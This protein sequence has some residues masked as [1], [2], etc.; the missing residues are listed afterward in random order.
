MNVLCQIKGFNMRS[1]K[2]LFVPAA[3]IFCQPSFAFTCYLTVMKSPCWKD[4]NINIHA[5]DQANNKQLVKAQALDK[6]KFWNRVK[7]DCNPKQALIFYAKF[8]PTIWED[9]KD[10]SYF[11]K[12]MWYLPYAVDPEISAWNI[13]ICYPVDFTDV[14]IPPS[15]NGNC[16]CDEVAKN[17]PPIPK[18]IISK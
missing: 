8:N 9:A 17:I 16:N 14:P 5:K 15:G 7:F 2:V 13:P 3:F 1:L 12:H 10:K 11:G 6:N 18:A 4:F